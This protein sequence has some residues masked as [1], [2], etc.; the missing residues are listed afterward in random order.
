MLFKEGDRIVVPEAYYTTSGRYGAPIGVEGILLERHD[1]LDYIWRVDF[2]GEE[3]WAGEQ[4]M[5]LVSKG[6]TPKGCITF[7]TRRNKYV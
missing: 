3:R 5:E 4:E 1:A 7:P 6:S 2:S